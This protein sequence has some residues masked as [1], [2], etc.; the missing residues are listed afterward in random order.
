[1]KKTKIYT[2]ILGQYG[3]IIMFTAV[4]KQIK[5]IIPNS[6]I[7]FAISKK[8]GDMKPLLERDPLINKVFVTEKY[9]EK[10]NHGSFFQRKKRIR[11]FNKGVYFDLRGEDEKKEQAKHDIVFETRPQHKDLKWFERTHQV[12]QLGLDIGINLKDNQTRLFPLSK[13][14]PKFKIKSKE[15]I[16]IHTKSG[17]KH[18]GWNKINELKKILK[19]EKLF[20]VQNEKTTILELATIIKN[21]KLFIGIDSM[22]IWIASSFDIPIIGLYG[23]LQYGVSTKYIYPKTK[24]IIPLQ[25]IGHPNKIKTSEIINAIKKLEIKL[26]D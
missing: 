26:N 4:I 25:V 9:F 12:N 2:G 8:Y 16:V 14:P 19:N 21:S 7:T 5:T 15:Y 18:K 20:I 23:S 22:P 1:M 6:E 24:K 17:A 13:I 10:L 11:L 3:D